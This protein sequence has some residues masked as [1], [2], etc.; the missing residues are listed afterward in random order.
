VLRDTLKALYRK[1]IFLQALL[2][3]VIDGPV[4]AMSAL[5]GGTAVLVSSIVYAAIA[6]E[7]RVTAV[8]AGSVLRRHLMA[9][10]GKIVAVLFLVLCALGSGWFVA[11]WLVAAM[12]VT[13]TGHWFL[14]FIIR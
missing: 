6:K 5:T 2:A 14:V 12:G 3:L 10:A 8:S 13:L 9:E 4:A 7:S 11:G 1:V